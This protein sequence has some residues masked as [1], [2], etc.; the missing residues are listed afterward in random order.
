MA[1]NWRETP[2]KSEDKTLRVGRRLTRLLL[3]TGGF[4]ALYGDLGAGKTT[5][6]RGMLDA[7]GIKDIQSPT[8]TIMQ[9]YETKKCPFYHLDAYRLGS[10]EELYDIGYEECLR[11]ENAIVAIEWA[12]LVQEALPKE[13]LDLRFTVA[14]NGGRWLH[15]TAYGERYKELLWKI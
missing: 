8:F 7:V 11:R 5:F 10:V 14:P 1:G 9:A 15:M 2:L 12:N 6:A 13:R 3:P 4:V